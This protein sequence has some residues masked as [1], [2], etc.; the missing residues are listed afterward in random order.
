MDA[1]DDQFDDL[2]AS[3]VGLAMVVGALCHIKGDWEAFAK[4]L[5]HPTWASY[6]SPCI[7]CHAELHEPHCTEVATLDDCSLNRRLLTHAIGIVKCEVW[8]TLTSQDE[9]KQMSNALVYDK[10]TSGTSA[11][12]CALEKK[13]VLPPSVW[14]TWI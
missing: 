6:L 7:L 4:V 12:G 9:R 5:G 14:N 11:M 10:R 13:G 2:R 1:C 8:V 3:L